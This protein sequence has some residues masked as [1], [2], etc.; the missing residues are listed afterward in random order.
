MNELT[1]TLIKV[2]P[3]CPHRFVWG[4]KQRLSGHGSTCMSGLLHRMYLS[5]V[6]GCFIVVLSGTPLQTVSVNSKPSSLIVYQYI[7]VHTCKSRN[8]SLIS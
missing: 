3:V 2:R 6:C 1:D 7:I 8:T 5:Q 4:S